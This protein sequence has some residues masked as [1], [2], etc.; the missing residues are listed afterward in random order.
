[1]YSGYIAVGPQKSLKR[2]PPS[3]ACPRASA[4]PLCTSSR[5]T[6]TVANSPRDFS[7]GEREGSQ[8]GVLRWI[9]VSRILLD[10]LLIR[11]GYLRV[12]GYGE[13]H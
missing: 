10:F 5:A 12:S 6:F 1:M 2:R 4:A 8:D 9:R 13:V 7:R 11:Y 3:C